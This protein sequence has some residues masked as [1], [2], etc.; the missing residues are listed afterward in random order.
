MMMD[1]VAGVPQVLDAVGSVLVSVGW[2]EDEIAAARRRWPDRA[3]E[4]FHAFGVI[5]PPRALESR[6]A[7]EAV[8]RAYARELL[9]RVRAVDEDQAGQIAT[10]HNIAAG[11]QGG[12]VVVCERDALVRPPSVGDDYL[13]ILDTSTTGPDTAP[14]RPRCRGWRRCWWWCVIPTPR[15]R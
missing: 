9:D 15:L 13:P 8:S 6:L 4:L 14:I 12:S 11:T 5:S 1:G 2:A 3:D 7:V 10:A